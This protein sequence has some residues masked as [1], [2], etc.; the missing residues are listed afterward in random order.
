MHWASKQSWKTALIT[1]I[2]Y[3]PDNLSEESLHSLITF[4]SLALSLSLFIILMT[5]RGPLPCWV[6]TRSFSP[7]GQRKKTNKPSSRE[8]R[9]WAGAPGRGSAGSL[10]PTQCLRALITSPTEIHY[11]VMGSL[12]S[13]WD[14]LRGARRMG[15]NTVSATVSISLNVLIPSRGQPLSLC[16]QH[17]YAHTNGWLIGHALHFD[18]TP[19]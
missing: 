13:F 16:V 7:T 18:G 8:A 9:W 10:L 1:S 12:A 6:G 19:F 14:A 3:K 17:T 4:K 15:P 11:L 2:S 5:P